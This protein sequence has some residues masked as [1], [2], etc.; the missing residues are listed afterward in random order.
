ME[1]KIDAESSH[2]I[3]FNVLVRKFKKRK[4]L[5]HNYKIIDTNLYNSWDELICATIRPLLEN[6]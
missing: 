6:F 5:E 2:T 3:C 4:I 1:K